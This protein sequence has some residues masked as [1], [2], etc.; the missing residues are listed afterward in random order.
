M[1]MMLARC[2][3]TL[4]ALLLLISTAWGGQVPGPETAPLR[5]QEQADLVRQVDAHLCSPWRRDVAWGAWYAAE[6]GLASLAPLVAQRLDDA[7]LPG[8]PLADAR[9]ALQDAAIRLGAVPSRTTLLRMAASSWSACVVLLCRHGRAH[10]HSML[11]VYDALDGYRT[12]QRALGNAMAAWRMPGFA[13]RVLAGLRLK[14]VLL[15][16]DRDEPARFRRPW[17]SVSGGWRSPS[18]DARF[19]PTV[20]YSVGRRGPHRL[21]DG[22]V[23]MRY[24]RLV[25]GPAGISGASAD[26]P[27]GLPP[28]PSHVDWLR[29]LVPHAPPPP[30]RTVAHTSI[31][32]TGRQPYRRA[33]RREIEEVHRRAF[34]WAD[35]LRAEG[36]ID[37]RVHRTFWPRVDVS[38]RDMRDDKRRA[39]PSV[40]I[41]VPTPR[42]ARGRTAMR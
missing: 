26:D 35:A 28:P 7:W 30:L 11:A 41:P 23:P 19:P 3:W 42:H 34:G 22:A 36:L 5:P 25:W 39:L 14:R 21:A 33:V 17:G 2:T 40:R 31:R 20:W 10:P 18:A 9:N 4:L 24:G 29:T 37:D 13:E 27:V 8:S 38:I 6:N 16:T 1:H 32:Y 15:I 12:A